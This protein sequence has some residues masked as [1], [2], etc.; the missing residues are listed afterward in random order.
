MNNH[1][2]NLQSVLKTML[3]LF[4]LILAAGCCRDKP[5][6]E[7]EK[8]E[9]KKEI[10]I[11]YEKHINDLVHLDFPEI[12]KYYADVDDH[13]LFG[14]GHYWGDRSKVESIWK[15]FTSS[16][17]TML[18]FKLKNH[19]VHVFT[20]DVASY[21]VEFDNVR[22]KGDG[23]TIKVKGCFSYGMQRFPDGWKVVTTQVTH[24]YQ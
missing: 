20:R 4:G 5:L 15:N 9:I 19:Y 12:M 17:D 16:V 13:I 2:E 22:V 7:E 6:T 23:D 1:R 21:L 18:Y 11:S 3:I 14:D 10:I 8:A 24:H